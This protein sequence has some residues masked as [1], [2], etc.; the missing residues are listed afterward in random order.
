MRLAV[1][2]RLAAGGL[3]RRP[4]SGAY[5]DDTLAALRAWQ[6]GKS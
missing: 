5:G 1:E 3:L 2:R 6:Q 4:P